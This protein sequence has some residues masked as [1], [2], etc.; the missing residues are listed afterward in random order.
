MAVLMPMTSPLEFNR[1]TRIDGGIGLN[2]VLCQVV[3]VRAKI[4]AGCRDDAARDRE[5]QPERVAH[6]NGFLSNL[7]RIAVAE[8]NWFE[9]L[10]GRINLNQS[11]VIGNRTTNQFRRVRASI[12]MKAHREFTHRVRLERDDMVV[13]QD[14]TII[15]DHKAR[16]GALL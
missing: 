11:Y 1:V 9:F 3:A 14:Q 2:H 4:A 16:T 10:T 8:W 13:G 7:D 15:G 6:R 5:C 12:P